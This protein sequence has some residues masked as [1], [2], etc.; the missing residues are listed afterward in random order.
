MRQNSLGRKLSLNPVRVSSFDKEDRD[1]TRNDARKPS[2]AKS[3]ASS[4][5]GD[6]SHIPRP[7]IRSIGPSIDGPSRKSNLKLPGKVSISHYGSAT[8]KTPLATSNRTTLALPLG[9]TVRGRSPSAERASALGVKGSRKD[10][11]PLSDKGYQMEMLRR[12]DEYMR[13]IE[14]S[15]LLNPSG[16][17][18]P[19]SLKMFV[20]VAAILFKL[21][22][23]KPILTMSN[24]IV[25]LPNISKKVHYPGIVNKSWLKTA[26]TMHSWPHVLGLLS[27]LVELC[28]VMDIATYS[29]QV[30][31][32]P[33]HGATA[34]DSL[35]NRS[36]FESMLNCYT[37]WN[38]DKLDEEEKLLKE[39]FQELA[40]QIG[41]DNENILAAQNELKV[42]QKK[43]T[44][45]QN[46]N[47]S[48]NKCTEELEDTLAS[49]QA[50][51]LKVLEDIRA[52][53]E[54]I[55]ESKRD[56]QQMKSE[57]VILQ[58]DIQKHEARKRELEKL[59]ADQPMS[60][61]ERDD[62]VERCS[63]SQNYLHQVD[64]LLMDLEKTIYSL[65]IKLA[66]TRN[67]LNKV[68]L[69]YNKDIVLNFNASI[70]ININDLMM[71]EKEI[72]S[73]LIFE[74][75]NEKKSFAD[76]FK[77]QLH[78]KLLLTENS[79]E[80]QSE[81]YEALQ[82]K[83]K[84]LETE[85]Q[86]VVE[87]LKEKKLQIKNIKKQYKEEEAFLR[88]QIKD[89]QDNIKL[90]QEPFADLESYT[91]DLEESREKLDALERRKAFLER[92]ASRF[93]TEFFQ[94]IAEHRNEVALILKRL[95]QGC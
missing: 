11:R 81:H 82:E 72:S 54:Y 93:F 94:I 13:N 48:A 4:T 32:L 76:R 17:L 87:N 35:F 24:Y 43:L 50:D 86:D 25:E 79:I 14:Q 26:N 57:I 77:E 23:V 21:L 20:D 55:N 68:I 70:D 85:H 60:A 78:Q 53:E 2:L 40:N 31:N 15:C 64:D 65:D 18:K 69:A 30:K 39:H 12:I 29:F 8:P 83:L 10:T 80:Q 47:R 3:R 92:Q 7:R 90:L 46:N 38:E 27:W 63:V 52:K 34:T 9:S 74:V 89:L 58:N 73:S 91:K 51:E 62:I 56:F 42:E 95:Q 41:V 19:I 67:N 37:A 71:P 1:P 22:D 61:A 5:S 16:S 59:I 66:S 49:L 36:T 88:K 84:N 33:Y 75:L 6:S 45:A 28:D 44:E